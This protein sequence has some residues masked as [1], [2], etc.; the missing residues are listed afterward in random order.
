[1]KRKER[2]L[3]REYVEILRTVANDLEEI[4]VEVEAH[5]MKVTT[6]RS[7]EWCGRTNR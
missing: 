5:Y 6:Q 3:I 1:M 7:P 4:A 2:K